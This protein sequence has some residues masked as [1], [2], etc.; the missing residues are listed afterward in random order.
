M[1]GGRKWR[2]WGMMEW[3]GWICMVVVDREWG[4]VG[5]KI[6]G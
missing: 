6:E 1:G 2:R 5:E 4:M 3:G